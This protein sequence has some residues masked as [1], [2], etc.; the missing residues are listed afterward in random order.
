M[1]KNKKPVVPEPVEGPLLKGR[2]PLAA[3]SGSFDKLNHHC[4][5][6]PPLTGCLIKKEC[7][8]CFTSHTLF[9]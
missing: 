2:L 3:N 9:F 8:F 1:K 6:L 7:A 5:P 4:F